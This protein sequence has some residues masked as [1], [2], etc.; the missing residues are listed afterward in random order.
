MTPPLHAHL[1]VFPRTIQANLDRVRASGLVAPDEVP[2]LW[3]IQLGVFRMWHRV[4]YRPESIG[5]CAEHPTRRTWRARLLRFRPLRFPFLLAER[6]VHPLDFSGLASHPERVV[7]HLLGAHHDGV[8]F[9]Y[10]LEL[11]CLEPERLRE[12]RE[13]ARAIVDGDHPRGEWLRDLVVYERYHENLLAAVDAFLD[14]A[15][16]VPASQKDDPDILFAAYLRWCARQPV[17][18]TETWRALRAGR[19][20]VADGLLDAEASARRSAPT[21]GE[22]A[23]QQ[24]LA[25]CAASQLA[26]ER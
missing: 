6:A 13:E 3:Q 12:V 16:E 26:P 25:A 1:L 22:Y 24:R 18:P 20:T 19:Y 7:R 17:T 5:T 10:D 9:H 23:R 11:L 21:Q 2:N 4:F 8:Q 15:L 14:G